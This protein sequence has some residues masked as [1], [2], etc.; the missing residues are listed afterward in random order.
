MKKISVILFFL[1]CIALTSYGQSYNF[2]HYKVENGLSYNSVISSLQD[3]KGFMWLGTKDGLNRFDGNT[4]KIF[5][6]DPDVAG[7]IGDN[8]IHCLF[9]DNKQNLWVGTQSGLFRYNHLNETFALIP[10]TKNKDIRDLKVDREGN[11]WYVAGTTLCMYSEQ[12]KK[13][14]AYDHREHAQVTSLVITAA[15]QVWAT[16]IDGYLQRFNSKSH[17]FENYNIFAHS[18]PAISSWIEKI[19][20][21]GRGFFL[22]GTSNQGVKSFDM[23]TLTYKDILNKNS[24]QTSIYARDFVYNGND[25]YWMATESG[26]FIY[27]IKTGNTI[28]VK[29]KINDPYSISDN[30]VYTLTRDKEGGIWA[31]TYFGGVNY[32]PRQYTHF[33]K[34]FPQGGSNSLS[35]YAVR[36]ICPDQ[37]GNLWIGTEDGGLNMLSLKTGKFKN[38]QPKGTKTSISHSNIHGLLAVGNELWVGTFEHGLDVLDINTN[39]VIRRYRAS[40]AA[41]ALKSN[42]VE[43]LLKTRSGDLLIGTS[44]GL[45]KY[46]RAADNFTLLNEVPGNFHYSALLEDNR[47]T[48]WAGTLRDGLYFFNPAN[49]TSG[50]Y[51][52]DEHDK[53]SLVSN[54]INSIFQD[55]KGHIWVTTENGLCLLNEKERNFT[56]LNTKDGFPSSVFYGILEDKNQNLWISTARGLV[57]YDPVKKTVK[58]YTKANGLLNNQFNYKSAFVD[59]QGLMYFGSV[60]GMISFVPESFVKNNFVSP[61]Y[62]TGFQIYN[63]EIQINSTGSPLTQSIN[64]TKELKLAHDQSTFSIDFAALGYTAPEMT[65]YKYVMD[66]LDKHWTYLPK[67]RKVYFTNLAPGSY[68][69]RVKAANSS[70]KWN[71]RE[72]TISVIIKPPFWKTNLAYAI[73]AILFAVGNYYFIRYYHQWIQDKSRRRVE[74]WEA[75]K[76]KELY[77][78][79]IEFFTNVTHEIRTPLTLISGPLDEIIRKS[80]SQS[81]IFGNLEMMKKNTERL[82]ALTDQLLDFR[83]AEV[84]GFSLNFVDVNVSQLLIANYKRYQ[85]AAVSKGLDLNIALPEEPV[86]AYADTEALNKILSN[87]ID[88]GLKYAGTHLSIILSANE[89]IF[90]IEV[91]SDGNII[92]PSVHEK[93]FEP[94]YRLKATMDQKGTGIGLPLARSLAE[95]HDGTLIVK[96]EDEQ[97]NVFVLSLPM[98]HEREFNLHSLDKTQPSAI[99]VVPNTNPDLPTILLVEDN[100]EIR[101][102]ISGQLLPDFVVIEVNNGEEAMQVLSEKSVHLIVSDIMM[103]VVN[104]FELCK[105]VKD[106]LDYTHIPIILLTASNSLQSRIEGLEVGADAYIEKPFSPAHL[107]KQ[108]SNLL[109]SRDKIKNY[110]A[111]SPLVHIKSM[112]YNKADE[113]FLERVAEFIN[114]NIDNKLN[115]DQLADLMNM[116]RPTFYRKIKTISN[117]SPLD[118]IRI[119]RLKKAAELLIEGEYSVQQIASMTGFSSQTHFGRSF[120]KQ[121]GIS[122]ME[123]ANSGK[124]AG[125][126]R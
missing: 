55:S 123:Y 83:K 46:N 114:K 91:K 26:L 10:Y 110:F 78:A 80:D 5:R 44:F 116:S 16:T 104:G 71:D 6:N 11:I 61:V 64:F 111:Q 124:K 62:I 37:N 15:D 97:W 29:N 90:T 30:S 125:V 72:T 105:M 13:M 117:L 122:P 51:Q 23:N 56:L 24:D 34:F 103:P 65:Q 47:G 1:F 113:V 41:N 18:E 93:I 120:M 17:T 19:Y 27:N 75:K 58:T 77:Q 74:V 9:E 33:N 70:N 63:Q 60:Q 112:A 109:A 21:S 2:R 12:T 84:K 100:I 45:Y 28:N 8:F 25:E 94:F 14:T 49:K 68:T 69:F 119:T 66:G 53:K 95:L 102:F 50:S 126:E 43:S 52:N 22:I 101:K 57:C 76:E 39:N 31:G 85:S 67:N 7:S 79:K 40:A 86:Y 87:L 38:F 32:Y 59:A 115:V 92:P 35:G 106:N 96:N 42:F 98:H 73:Y 48:I 89:N 121:F 88:N 81:V 4:F 3:K 107:L 82:I 99:E 54:D 108:I 36:E 20:D 118:L